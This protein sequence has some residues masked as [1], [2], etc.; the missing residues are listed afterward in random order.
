MADKLAS[1]AYCTWPA[2][3]HSVALP[4]VSATVLAVVILH[5]AACSWLMCAAC[6]N[7]THTHRCTGWNARKMRYGTAMEVVKACVRVFCI[8][9]CMRDH[10]IQTDSTYCRLH[11]ASSGIAVVCHTAG[12]NICSGCSYH[13]A[14]LPD[15][16]PCWACLACSSCS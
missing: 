15:C 4:G 9:T 5:I 3:E 13:I 7:C 1:S 8:G 10:K 6:V 2:H 14:I 11:I 12:C 16:L